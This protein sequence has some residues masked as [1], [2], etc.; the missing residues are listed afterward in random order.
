MAA[1][2]PTGALV[3]LHHVSFRF[4]DGVTLFDSLDL[5]IDRTPTGIVGRN[6]VG[7]SLLAQLIAGCRAPSAGTIER[8]AH[9][10]YVAQQHDHDRDDAAAAAPRTVAQIA[11]LD[12]P[13]G[14]LARLADGHATPNDF[15]LIG[16]RW[17]LAERLRM[18]LD[19]AG[20]HDVHAD[21]PAH[22]LSGGQVARV[23]LIGALLSG[24]G[25][26]VLDEPTNHLDAPGRAWLRTALD[27]WRGGVVIVSHDRALLAGVQRIV[28]LT[29]HG[30]RSYG[31][32]YALYRAQRDAE[33]QAAHAA[34]DH[35]RTERGRVRRRL[36]Q[37]HDTIQ[38]HAAASL[39][40][41][42]TVNLSSM[43]R[44]SRKG[45]A[46]AI[47]GTVR[48]HQSDFKATLD[49]RVQEAAA[50]VEA[51]APVLVSLPGT[52]VSARRQL[53]TL[54]RAQLPWRVA[55]DADAI[56]W[57]ASGAVRIALT[58]PNGCGKSTLLR[59]LAGELAPRSGTCTT[60][61]SAAYLDQRLALLDPERSIVE[62]LGLLDTPLAEGD[63]R[64]RLAL[65]QLDAT[66]ATQPARQLSGG[67]RLKAALACALWRGT[68]AQLLLLDE[69]T[70]H[71]DLESVRAIEA[72]LA[73]F[74]GAIVVASH[75]AAFLAALEPTHTMQWHR[76]G[77]RYEPVA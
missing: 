26:L 42:K 32:N 12:A 29:P 57:S 9:V 59:M 17:D 5:S 11:A 10:V 16:D 61:V 68:P 48:R 1:A 72:A 14:A 65:L 41:A 47:M 30:A 46:R 62:Q 20:L 51:D 28:E 77:W 43:A 24:A 54:E 39:R 7:K 3:A 50:R 52:E 22:A 8:H 40:D 63:L 38:R 70:N 21:T 31:G 67:E 15:D 6:G 27:G 34:L 75:D 45:A 37:E 19:A 13:L 56:T 44:Q 64:S 76:D 49:A 23:A 35:A 4:D 2:T 66:R 53:F 69:P 33:H 60:H 58:G 18:A 36:E 73:G 71:L 55:G 25:L 74:P